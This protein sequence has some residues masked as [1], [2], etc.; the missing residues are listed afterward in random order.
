MAI[1]SVHPTK[2]EVNRDEALSILTAC[3]LRQQEEGKPVHTWEMPKQSDLK[4]YRPSALTVEEF[5]ETDLFTIQEDDLIEMA[6]NLMDWRKI[7]HMPVEN[8]KGHLVG[9]VTSRMM[10][11]YYAN[12]KT[13]N[14]AEVSAVRDIMIHAP[15]TISPDANLLKAMRLMREHRIGCLQLHKMMN[16]LASLPKWTSSVSPTAYWNVWR[17]KRASPLLVE[18]KKE[19]NK[20]VGCWEIGLTG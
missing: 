18:V 9:L 1:E 2:K 4:E 10:L 17:K 15:I 5:M 3:I 20:V 13:W 6:A 7:R 11:R 8:T 14:G 19:R 12:G 16:S